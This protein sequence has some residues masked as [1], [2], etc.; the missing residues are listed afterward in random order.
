MTTGEET[1]DYLRRGLCLVFGHP[2]VI[3]WDLDALRSSMFYTP[4]TCRASFVHRR[5]LNVADEN[6]V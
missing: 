2:W 1:D 5:K 4:T 3:P 6:V